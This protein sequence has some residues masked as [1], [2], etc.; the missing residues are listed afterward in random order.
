MVQA[1]RKR[2]RIGAGGTIQVQSAELP[3]GSEAEVIV[4]LEEQASAGNETSERP[5]SP[6]ATIIGSGSGGFGSVEEIDQYIRDLR[7]EWD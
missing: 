6:L 1:L 5:T 2:V 4:L 7:D 3:E